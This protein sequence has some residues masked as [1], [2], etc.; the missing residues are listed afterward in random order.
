MEEHV[1][2]IANNPNYSQEALERLYDSNTSQP[3]TTQPIHLPHPN[4]EDI[5]LNSVSAP[6]TANQDEVLDRNSTQGYHE[7]DD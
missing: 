2:M 7:M 6:A 1:G 3:R 4:G 5:R